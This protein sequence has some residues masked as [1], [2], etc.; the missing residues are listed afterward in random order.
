[1]DLK[2]YFSN[3]VYQEIEKSLSPD[4]ILQLGSNIELIDNY[5]DSTSYDEVLSEWMDEQGYYDSLEAFVVAY[6][7]LKNKLVENNLT[8]IPPYKA[9]VRILS[10]LEKFDKPSYNNQELEEYA[11]ASHDD[12][13]RPSRMERPNISDIKG[14]PWKG[15]YIGDQLENIL[16]DKYG[17]ERGSKMFNGLLDLNNNAIYTV[18]TDIMKEKYKMLLDLGEDPNRIDYD[19][20]NYFNLWKVW[21][22][23]KGRKA[24]KLGKTIPL[25]LE[26]GDFDSP[27]V[28]QNKLESV[29][30]MSGI[31]ASDMQVNV[32]DKIDLTVWLRP[33]FKNDQVLSMSKTLKQMVQSF[34]VEPKVSAD[35]GDEGEIIYTLTAFLPERAPS[36]P[37]GRLTEVEDFIEY[38][39]R[40][41]KP[42]DGEPENQVDS[43]EDIDE[44]IACAK[45]Y[46]SMVEYETPTD[47]GIVDLET[48]RLISYNKRSLK[49]ESDDESFEYLGYDCKITK[50][51]RFQDGWNCSVYK[52]GKYQMG[53]K[54]PQPLKKALQ[55]A[56]DFV[57]R[58]VSKLEDNLK[59]NV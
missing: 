46:N 41:E 32:D 11:N 33:P 3:E 36:E 29:L 30:T 45:H 43:F 54:G 2:N 40:Y 7:L 21:V 56:K 44:A 17:R 59:Y 12:E 18:C 34:G 26:E 4:E 13:S 38:T 58:T 22:A 39:V 42:V 20:I 9:V 10:T 15:F 28:M 16:V 52:D 49:E 51:P 23:N 19:D 25:S 53:I 27:L 55:T 6:K 57:D 50:I 5:S 8:N 14:N 1:M 24:T 35:Y 48:K 31:P 37:E 47:N